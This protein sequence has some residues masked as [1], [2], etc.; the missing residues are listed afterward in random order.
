MN[1]VQY[2]QRLTC[3]R[4][5]QRGVLSILNNRQVSKQQFTFNETDA[6]TPQYIIPTTTKDRVIT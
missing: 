2:R 1:I 5:T 6:I 4:Y 3:A